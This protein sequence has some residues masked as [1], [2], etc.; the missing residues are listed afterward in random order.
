LINVTKNSYLNPRKKLNKLQNFTV[1]DT[2]KNR[3]HGWYIK[4]N[5][6]KNEKVISAGKAVS[7]YL[8]IESFIPKTSGNT[9]QANQCVA[10]LG[11]R[12]IWIVDLKDG[13]GYFDKNKDRFRKS[14]QSLPAE[15]L[16]LIRHNGNY[17]I[18]GTRLEAAGQDAVKV[19]SGIFSKQDL[20]WREAIDESSIF[21]EQL[22]MPG[23]TTTGQ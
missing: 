13:H 22:T 23:S 8:A 11:E 1:K 20:G 12:R 21:S 14:G 19:G 4:L 17:L 9:Q 10:N 18:T 6:N 7:G 2:K 16:G 3:P 5:K 15:R